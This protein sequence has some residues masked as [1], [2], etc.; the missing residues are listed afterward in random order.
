MFTYAEIETQK[1]FSNYVRKFWVLDNVASPLYSAGKYTLPNGCFTLAFVSGGGLIW[2]N[3][4][5]TK[6]IDAGIYLIGQTTK[7]LKVSLLPHTK[8][9]MAQLNPW[10]ASL[11]TALPLSELTDDFLSLEELDKRCYTKL[12]DVEQLDQDAVVAK[13]YE[14]FG[15]RFNAYSNNTDLL[16]A[17]CNRF[18]ADVVSP[19]LTM[20]DVASY[21]GYSKRYIEKKFDNHIGLSPKGFHSILRMRGVINDL[22]KNELSLTELCYKYGYYDQS[23]FIKSYSKIMGSRP[24]GFNSDQYILPIS[25]KR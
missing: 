1:N 19:S 6:H 14:V 5:G 21:A 15:P 8:A 22:D 3:E 23:H 9:I 18:A 10:A 17:L 16:Q 13:F 12:I 24:T 7:R 25:F 20:G 2:E 11:I 4:Y